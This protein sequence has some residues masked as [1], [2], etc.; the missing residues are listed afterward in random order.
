M[1]QDGPMASLGSPSARRR[2]LRV[3][4]QKWSQR[5]PRF[6][7]RPPCR[8]CLPGL[9]QPSEQ[10]SG[11]HL[12]GIRAASVH[13]LCPSP[14]W[15]VTLRAGAGLMPGHQISGKCM[16]FCTPVPVPAVCLVSQAAGSLEFGEHINTKGSRATGN[17][18]WE[19]PR[20]SA[21][22]HSQAGLCGTPW[23]TCFPVICCQEEDNAQRV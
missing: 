15:S 16:P 22:H 11:R 19:A 1:C 14:H 5:E 10:A 12:H 8:V 23:Q 13:T 21:D 20:A 17:C 2:G 7:P 9:S 3:P 18:A 4:R 6:P